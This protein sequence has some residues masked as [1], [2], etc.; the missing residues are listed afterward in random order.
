MWGMVERRQQAR[1]AREA[2][3]A[4]GVGREVRRQDLDRDV[5]PELAVAGAIHL[6]HAAGAERRDGCVGPELTADHSTLVRSPKDVV[7]DNR[8]R[9]FKESRAVGLVAQQRLEF[10]AQCR[11]AAAR[12]F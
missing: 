12:S 9:Y 4:L 7:G 11:I 10:A 2:G 5:A 1:L 6:A 3:A 8:R